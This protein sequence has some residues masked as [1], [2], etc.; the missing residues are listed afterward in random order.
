MKA[1]IEYT[2]GKLTWTEVD[3]NPYARTREEMEEWIFDVAMR[4]LSGKGGTYDILE[5]RE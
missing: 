4:K 1:R 3:E 5:I 2:I